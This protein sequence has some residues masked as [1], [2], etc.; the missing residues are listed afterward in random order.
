MEGRTLE[1]WSLWTSLAWRRFLAWSLADSYLGGRAVGIEPAERDEARAA[2]PAALFGYVNGVAVAPKNF[3]APAVMASH[4]ECI[5][6]MEDSIP[7][8]SYTLNPTPRAASFHR[9]NVDHIHGWNDLI[10]VQTPCLAV[11]GVRRRVMA[12][13]R[14]QSPAISCVPCASV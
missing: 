8:I 11:N 10:A 7:Y 6:Y 5:E 14:R 2:R 9:K 1:H 4:N 3:A 13:T 12:S